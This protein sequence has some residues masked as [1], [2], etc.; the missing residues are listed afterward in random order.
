M[1][2]KNQLRMKIIFI[3][4]INKPQLMNHLISL[5]KET[6]YKLYSED[7]LSFEEMRINHI[8]YKDNEGEVVAENLRR[9]E[10]V[11]L[12]YFVL[13]NCVLTYAIKTRK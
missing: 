10:S 4:S 11:C 7:D 3:L 8:H 1:V 13:E 6:L 2:T 12:P 5:L 9:M